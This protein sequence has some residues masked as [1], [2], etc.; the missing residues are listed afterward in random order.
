MA[1]GNEICRRDLGLVPA[2]SND[3]FMQL[4]LEEAEKLLIANALDSEQGNVLAAAEKLGIS[5]AALYRRLEKYGDSI[6]ADVSE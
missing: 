2:Q 1:D 4:T 5:R 3:D 6:S